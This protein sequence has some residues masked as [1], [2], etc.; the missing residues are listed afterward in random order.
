M[1]YVCNAL[2]IALRTILIGPT[3]LLAWLFESLGEGFNSLFYWLRDTL[4]NRRRTPHELRL[5]RAYLR[6]QRR[7]RDAAVAEFDR[8]Y[9]PGTP[10]GFDPGAPTEFYV[11]STPK[12]TDPIPMKGDQ[13]QKEPT[14]KR[15]WYAVSK[16]EL[17]AIVDGYNVEHSRMTTVTSRQDRDGSFIDGPTAEVEAVQRRVVATPVHEELY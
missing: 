15:V 4:P 9:P 5:Y 16:A 6:D 11:D 12:N 1:I 7:K 8:M 2:V 3:G 17:D 10:L 13:Q 14:M